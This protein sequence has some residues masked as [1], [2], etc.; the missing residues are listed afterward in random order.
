MVIGILAVA[1]LVASACTATDSNETPVTGNSSNVTGTPGPTSTLQPTPVPTSTPGPD[2]GL[3][4]D[5]AVAITL[6]ETVASRFS[7]LYPDLHFYT[8]NL[9][10]GTT[11][12]VDITDTLS[13]SSVS[14]FDAGSKALA[15]NTDTDGN[16]ATRIVW[17]APRSGTYFVQVIG[18]YTNRY[19][20]TVTG[21][22]TADSSTTVPSRLGPGEDFGSARPL[23]LG[24]SVIAS[25]PSSV[26][27]NPESHYY[28]VV[29]EEGVT[30]SIDVLDPFS[31]TTVFLADDKR[32]NLASADESRNLFATAIQ[33]KAEQSGSYFI[34]VTGSGNASYGLTVKSPNTVRARASAQ[35]PAQTAVPGVTPAASPSAGALIFAEVTAGAMHTCGVTT[36]GAAYCWGFGGAGQLGDGS[37]TIS[38]MTPVAVSG[39]LTFA[40]VSAGGGYTCGV[41]NSGAAY[42]W[43]EGENGQLGN[44]SERDQ[45]RP[46]A[47]SGRLTFATVS[48]GEDHACGVTTTG[49]AYCWGNNFRGELGDGSQRDQTTPVAVSGGLTFRTI[50]AGFF[51]TCGVTTIG[52]AYCW[53]EGKVGQLGNGSMDLENPTPV[54][55]SRGLTFAEVS[56]SSRHTC[57]VTTSGAAYCWGYGADG[58]LGDG[59]TVR[60]TMPG[61]GTN[62]RQLQPVPVSGG[63][64]FALVKAGSSHTCG[65]TTSGAAYCWGTS[66]TGVLGDDNAADNSTTPVAVSGGLVFA[67]LSAGDDHNCGVTTGGA[68]YCWGWPSPGKLGDGSGIPQFTPAAVAPPLGG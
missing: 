28:E 48:A 45:A 65:V 38:Q 36:S 41:T 66:G 43:G 25:F 12:T 16:R 27:S 3:T 1:A 6:G 57:G 20:L 59:V 18:A 53:G 13:R 51:H 33:W 56:A 30:Y 39:G 63:L 5:D 67:S 31:K 19:T 7:I 8:V 21:G 44:G 42:C 58:M 49:D 62:D 14:I 34:I 60:Q 50:S 9:E 46:A 24:E 37:A 23:V 55:V 10:E 26:E 22:E 32:K 11:Y 17:T 47:V 4:R 52:A 15:R 40:S 64:T 61:D 54:A 29:F 68:A 35:K 2:P